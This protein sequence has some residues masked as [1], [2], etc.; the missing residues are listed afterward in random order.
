MRGGK[1]VVRGRSDVRLKLNGVR[2]LLS[3]VDRTLH[4]LPQFCDCAQLQAVA[5]EPPLDL[6]FKKPLVVVLY[7]L[8]ERDADTGEL[9]LPDEL[10]ANGQMPRVPFLF[11]QLPAVPTQPH[12]GKLARLALR[13]QAEQCVK[14]NIKKIARATRLERTEC[15]YY[16]GRFTQVESDMY[17]ALYESLQVVLVLGPTHRLGDVGFD[18]LGL[19]HL[20]LQQQE[21]GYPLELSDLHS[22]GI[23]TV[24]DLIA[25]TTCSLCSS[26]IASADC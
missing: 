8:K 3:E 16:G 24:G 10:Y 20:V 21:R 26:A 13:Q 1:L 11:C 9:D 4:E 12:T 7:V 14:T 22:S 2:A 19:T 6:E 17:A 25:A 15:D 18:L 23:A 5:V